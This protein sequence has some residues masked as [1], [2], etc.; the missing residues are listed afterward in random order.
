VKL[1]AHTIF[2]NPNLVSF[3]RNSTKMITNKRSHENTTKSFSL[4]RAGLFKYLRLK[5]MTVIRAAGI[6]VSSP[7]QVYPTRLL[8]SHDDVKARFICFSTKIFQL[9]GRY[10]IRIRNFIYVISSRSVCIPFVCDVFGSRWRKRW[11][12]C[13]SYILTINQASHCGGR[14]EQ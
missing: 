4:L 10:S 13:L 9:F 11:N 2:T 5:V 3:V 8:Q 1:S 12:P 6:V 7:S 14:G